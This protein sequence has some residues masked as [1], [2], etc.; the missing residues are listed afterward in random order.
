MAVASLWISSLS[1]ISDFIMYGVGIIGAIVGI[2]LGIGVLRVSTQG[3][4]YWAA[5]GRGF[6]RGGIIVGT[7][8]LVLGI[9]LL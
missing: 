9:M 1:F 8:A 7:L 6:A 5:G 4:E 2:F 3:K